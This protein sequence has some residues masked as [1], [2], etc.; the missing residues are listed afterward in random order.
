MSVLRLVMCNGEICV[1]FSTAVF[2]V[3]TSYSVAELI[4]QELFRWH[5]CVFLLNRVS[6]V[7]TLDIGT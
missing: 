7:V 1:T 4:I 6:R 5:L 2:L 3:P